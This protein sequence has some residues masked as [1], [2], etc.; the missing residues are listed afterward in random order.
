MSRGSQLFNDN[1]RGKPRLRTLGYGTR[2]K[3]K[4]SIAQLKKMPPRYQ[5]QA[6]TT[7]Y[8]RAKYHRY[9][10][11]DMEEAME[12]YGKF[13]R[14]IRHRDTGGHSRRVTGGQDAFSVRYPELGTVDG[15]NW[16]TNLGSAALATAPT[17][18]VPHN[19]SSYLLIMTDPNAPSGCFVHWIA[20]IQGSNIVN[21]IL[22]NPPSPPPGTGT[23]N[24]IFTLYLLDN[25][26]QRHCLSTSF[27]IVA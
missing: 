5:R 23:H 20:E 13:L 18:T 14:R 19:T 16:T 15:Q 11:A 24:Y 8:Y 27:Y 22:Y 6:A 3:A 1:P 9:R 25:G 10:T 4:N 26:S 12:E 17:V 7:M 2:K 21:R